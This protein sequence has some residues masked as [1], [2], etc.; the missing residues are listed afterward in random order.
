MNICRKDLIGW[1]KLSFGNANVEIE[2]VKRRLQ[3]LGT[4][5]PSQSRIEDEKALKS[6]VNTLW[7]NE[8]NYWRQRSRVKW[9]LTQG[10]RNSKFFHQMTL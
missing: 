8:K 10:D 4:V 9:M 3:Q 5:A 2:K 1:S 7:K 6:K